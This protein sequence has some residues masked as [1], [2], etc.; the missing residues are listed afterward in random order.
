MTD[1][2]DT[3]LTALARVAAA[4]PPYDRPTHGDRS[5]GVQMGWDL[6]R[7]AALNA[8]GQPAPAPAATE[9]TELRT[10]LA[11]VL[12]RLHPY[13]RVGGGPP[14]GYQILTPVSPADYNRW[15]AALGPASE[16]DPPAQC[17][18]TE[19]GTPCDWDVCNQPERLAAGDYGT[20]PREQ[21]P[22]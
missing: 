20:D 4:L 3:A 18:H 12:A 15:T 6:A 14:L 13:H 19:A 10:A 7:Q 17:W 22:T 11:E 9:A 21:P 8:I 1:S 2:L 16:D 5:E